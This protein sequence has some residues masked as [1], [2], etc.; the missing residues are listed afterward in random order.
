MRP[1]L[2]VEFFV[3]GGFVNFGG[4]G[5]RSLVGGFHAGKGGGF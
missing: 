3:G 1:T 5:R 2:S 4:Y